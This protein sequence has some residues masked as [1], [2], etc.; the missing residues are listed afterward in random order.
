MKK[1]RIIIACLFAISLAGNAL[2]QNDMT[3][4]L[5]GQTKN[6]ISTGM[7][8]L[9]VSPDAIASGMGDAGAASTPDIYSAH[10]NNAKFAFIDGDIG[11]GTTYTPW[12]RNLNVADMNLLYLGGFKRINSRSTVAASLTYF[13]LGEIQ[14]TDADGQSR[15][16]MNPNEFAA[17]VTYAMKLNDELSLGA[18]GRFINSDLTNGQQ[19]SDGSG[20]VSTKPARSIAADLGLYWQHPIDN[21]QVL[22][23]GAFISNMGAK[24]SYSD[25]DTKKEFLPSNLRIGARYTNHIDESNSI[26]LLF[27][28]N[29]L[30]VPTPPI[31]EGDSTY[32]KYYRNMTEYYSTG[33]M[34]GAIQSFYDAPRGLSEEFQEV[35]ISAGGEYWYKQ[36]L[37]A[38]AGYFYE[39][40]T[41]GGRQYLT[42]GF[43]LKYSIMQFDFAYLVPTT[44]FSSN[45]LS[46]TIRISLTLNFKAKKPTPTI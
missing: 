43:G 15:G 24:L 12:L 5:T 14:M 16:T 41:K 11:L 39:S 31:T 42:F 8:I 34:K 33:V 27:D 18:T 36:T 44:S 46:N 37:A 6:Y 40:N 28:V 10:W 26:S 32:S 4:G 7:P 19:V 38:R 9:L 35:Q 13:S 3:P 45:P 1:T 29:K 23:I 25:D 2:A 21:S 20:Y 22:A 30:L 17:D